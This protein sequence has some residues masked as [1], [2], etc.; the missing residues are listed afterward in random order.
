[1]IEVNK[2]SGRCFSR[3]LPTDQNSASPA[4]FDDPG[5]TRDNDPDPLCVIVISALVSERSSV[6]RVRTN[7]DLC[8]R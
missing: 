5:Q 6:V 4:G 8:I 1:M 7:S 3:R 2:I